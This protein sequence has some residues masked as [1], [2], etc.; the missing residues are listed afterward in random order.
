LLQTQAYE[1]IFPLSR[2]PGPFLGGRSTIT[3]GSFEDWPPGLCRSAEAVRTQGP[4]TPRW[5]RVQRLQVRAEQLFISSRTGVGKK[6][7]GLQGTLSRKVKKPLLLWLGQI[8]HLKNS[9]VFRL[10][11][12]FWEL[13]RGRQVRP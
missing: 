1:L 2:L 12:F 7:R 3:A 4:R 5:H 8:N 10:H 9:N 11:A 6:A 13:K